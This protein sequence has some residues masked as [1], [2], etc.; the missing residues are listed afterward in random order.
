MGIRSNGIN[1][2]AWPCCSRQEFDVIRVMN[3][4]EA[5]LE[6]VRISMDVSVIGCKVNVSEAKEAI[7]VWWVLRQKVWCIVMVKKS[8][9]SN[10]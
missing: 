3:A 10:R 2:I 4:L 6:D 8:F 1:F 7:L 5:R 9:D